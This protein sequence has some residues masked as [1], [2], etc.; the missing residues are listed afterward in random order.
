MHSL[1][2]VV[3]ALQRCKSKA[4]STHEIIKLL[5]APVEQGKDLILAPRGRMNGPD[6]A[7]R[8]SEQFSTMSIGA[9]L[10]ESDA[11]LNRN[12][13]DWLFLAVNAAL[14]H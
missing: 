11:I 2:R 13:G 14:V 9:V 7:D 1:W 3:F 8:L 5:I 4:V 12:V 10:T 6:P